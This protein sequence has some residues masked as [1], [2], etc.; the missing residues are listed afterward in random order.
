MVAAAAAAEPPSVLAD[1]EACGE[2]VTCRES[3]EDVRATAFEATHLY[4]EGVGCM[5][6]VDGGRWRAARM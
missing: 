1:G 5:H 3:S 2:M 4:M 6:L